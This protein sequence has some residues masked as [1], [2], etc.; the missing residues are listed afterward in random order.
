V[1]DN[2]NLKG[3]SRADDRPVPEREAATPAGGA[4]PA[5]RPR[6]PL[7]SLVVAAVA[8]ASLGATAWLYAE[9][10][11]EIR[12]VSTDIAQIR[13]SLELFGQQQQAA[14]SAP[15]D[16]R[17][18]A[19]QALANRVA[20][21]EANP[22]TAPASLPPLASAAAAP[23]GA[24]AAGDDCLPVGMRFMM[25]A[26]DSYPVCGTTGVVGIAA[27]DN[28]YVTL[29]DG[30]IVAQGGTVGLPETQCMLGVLPS[31]GDALSG[32]AEVRVSC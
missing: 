31:A 19:L 4:A 27:V 17:D 26:G 9:T 22:V 28:G 1:A 12:R 18:A 5:A 2:W 25:A 23:G 16:G 30:T 13:L 24:A 29:A 20:L 6:P 11:R 8:L 7:L 32:F 10:Q 21:L 14:G 15:A 3:V